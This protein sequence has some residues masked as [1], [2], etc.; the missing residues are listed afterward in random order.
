MIE[1][2]E[3]DGNIIE[4]LIYDSLLPVLEGQK[5]GHA[6][7]GCLGTACLLMKPELSMDELQG[8]IMAASEAIILSM[9]ETPTQVH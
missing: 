6:I 2:V 4:G 5:T 8:A 3:V 9:M 7:M 1:Q